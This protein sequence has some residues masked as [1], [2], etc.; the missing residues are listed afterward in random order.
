VHLH[1]S[2]VGSTAR[3]WLHVA[4]SNGQTL[5]EGILA[6]GMPSKNFTDSQLLSMTVGNAGVVDLVVNGKDR[7]LAGG[8]GQVVHKT[9]HPHRASSRA[10]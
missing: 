9:F 7:G 3:S 2:I 4:G 8:S 10:G 5:F 6:A 1:V